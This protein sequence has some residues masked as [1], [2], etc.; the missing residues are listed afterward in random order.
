MNN[1]I[2]LKSKGL[3]KQPEKKE[4]FFLRSTIKCI[5]CK[6]IFPIKYDDCPQCE[7]DELY[8]AFKIKCKFFFRGK[9]N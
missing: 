1:T 2:P 7:L 3:M 5:I 6:A 8:R 9:S 4:L